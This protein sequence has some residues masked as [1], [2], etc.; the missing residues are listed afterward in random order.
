MV[1]NGPDSY[2]SPSIHRTKQLPT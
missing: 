1:F 2:I